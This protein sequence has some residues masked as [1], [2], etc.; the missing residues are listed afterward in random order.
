MKSQEDQVS[1]K[2]TLTHRI[3][4]GFVV[5]GTILLL[6]YM[7]DLL[8][9]DNSPKVRF[10]TQSLTIL[11]KDDPIKFNGVTI[12]KVESIED[13][14]DGV[15]ITGRLEKSVKIPKSARVYE[16]NIG[17]FNE[18][19]IQISADDRGEDPYADG[20]TIPLSEPKNTP[21]NAIRGILS[22]Q[23][24]LDTIIA[25]IRRI[26]ERQNREPSIDPPQS[27]GR[28]Q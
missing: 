17:F 11:E 20:E 22:T 7:A 19:M 12:G 27:T 1:K 26:E 9:P 23:D 2:R 15:V 14:L 10:S 8:F 6:L 13:S 21:T 25:V 3:I 4:G 24:K 18:G 16:S 5:I 28:R